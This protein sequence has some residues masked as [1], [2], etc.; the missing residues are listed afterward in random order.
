MGAERSLTRW[1]G[2]CSDAPQ[3]TVQGLLEQIGLVLV[4]A[5]VY[6]VARGSTV[7]PPGSQK[8]SRSLVGNTAGGSCSGTD[9]VG[10]EVERP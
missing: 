7:G 10:S 8:P 5:E 1:L 4:G 6:E 2:Q 3:L 9:D